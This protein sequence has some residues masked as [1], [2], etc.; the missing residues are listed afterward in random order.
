MQWRGRRGSS[1]IED[2]R[3]QS[4]GLRGAGVGGVGL[5]AV[6]VI[7]YVFG[8]DLTPLLQGGPG[9][10]PSR[11]PTELSAEDQALGQFVSVTLADTEEVWAK[12]FADQLG[13][14][15]QP[16]RLVLFRDQTDSGCG[17][18]SEATGPF[19]C[20]VDRS[21]YLDTGFFALLDQQLGASGDFAAAYVVAHEVGHHVQDELGILEQTDRS[22]QSLPEAQANAVSV[23]VELMADCLAGVWAHQAERQ[24]GSL[25]P[26]DL[27]EAMN[28][29]T[30]IGDDALQR[31]AG[32]RPVPDSFTHGSSAQRMQ[33]F[34]TG[35]ASGQIESCNTFAD[36]SLAPD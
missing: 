34:Q 6:V 25:E 10:A 9:P 3:S 13:R 11:Q 16:A 35:Q 28:A 15:Y 4:G 1:N 18:A 5:L 26:G 7:G 21:I 14:P 19:Y 33:W 23:Q 2:R 20:P 32:Q 36:R 29:A 24:F 12:L 27:A 31:A 8:V 17:G 22:R 30:R